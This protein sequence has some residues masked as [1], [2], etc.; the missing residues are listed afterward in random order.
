MNCTMRIHHTNNT[1]TTITGGVDDTS[2]SEETLI[3]D[4]VDFITNLTCAM[5]DEDFS[6]PDGNGGT[7][8]G[9]FGEVRAVAL[10]VTR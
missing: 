8:T 7:V 4:L 6:L 3:V 2:A 9:L 1:T 5:P 10:E